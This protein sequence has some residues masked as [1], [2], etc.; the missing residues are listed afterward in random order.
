M[1][2]RDKT[3][4]E[5]GRNI[6]RLRSNAGLSRDKLAEKATFDRTYLA[7]PSTAFENLFTMIFEIV[8]IWRS[9]FRGK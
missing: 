5:F 3:L 9:D 2:K 6:S 1:P 4:T 7:V 8:E